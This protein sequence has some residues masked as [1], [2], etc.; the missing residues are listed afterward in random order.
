MHTA[1]V[2]AL[3]TTLALSSFL[4]ACGSTTVTLREEPTAPA[5]DDL[6]EYERGAHPDYAVGTW[7]GL[8]TTMQLEPD[9]AAKNWRLP[10]A[11]RAQGMV[12]L[13]ATRYEEARRFDLVAGCG[14]LFASAKAHADTEVYYQS[15]EVTDCPVP[16]APLSRLEQCLVGY[17]SEGGSTYVLHG[18]RVMTRTRNGDST[19]LEIGTWT[20]DPTGITFS[21]YEREAGVGMPTMTEA[22]LGLRRSGSQEC[23]EGHCDDIRDRPEGCAAFLVDTLLPPF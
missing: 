23:I 19:Q 4:A 11:W 22:R 21:R 3:L 17:L 6:D 1:R 15:R 14:I 10:G 13:F 7:S 9:G 2:F 5:Q 8:P 12:V 16:A 20:A 18:N